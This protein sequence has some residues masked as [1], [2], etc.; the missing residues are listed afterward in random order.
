MHFVEIP[1]FPQLV[2][3]RLRLFCCYFESIQFL[4]QII[5][6]FLQLFILQISI[7]HLL[8]FP[9]IDFTFLYQL[10]PLLLKYLQTLLHFMFN[11]EVPDEIVDQ[12]Q[13]LNSFGLQF[14]LF[15]DHRLLLLLNLGLF[16]FNHHI[17]DQFIQIVDFIV[18]NIMLTNTFYYFVQFFW[19]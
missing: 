19:F 12:F 2:I 6:L 15:F 18:I 11:K 8:Q 4:F 1:F 5:N 9:N 3:S 16:L 17:I 13:P 10:I 14:L 7:R